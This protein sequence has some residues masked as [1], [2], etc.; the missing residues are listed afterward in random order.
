MCGFIGSVTEESLSDVLVKQSLDLIKHRGPDNIDYNQHQVSNLNILFGHTRLSIIDLTDQASQP[1]T[2]SCGKFSIIFNGEIYNY[3]EIREELLKL[4]Y[5]FRTESDTEV[6]LNSLICWG[7]TS[8]P[9]FI[10]MFSFVF[11]DKES[12]EL[13][14]A[15][16]AFGIKPFFY[17][18]ERN[19][20]FFSS[21]IPALLKLRNS[22]SKPNLQR[23]YDYL[24]H[25]EYDSNH[26]S[27]IEGVYHLLPAHYMKF[28]ISKGSLT[29]QIK[30]WNPSIKDHAISYDDAKQKLRDLFLD[31]VRLHLRSDVPIGIALSGGIDSSAVACA[32][33]HYDHEVEINTFS[34]IASNEL[35][36]EEL[37][38]DEI[39][40]KINAKPHKVFTDQ[41]D[42]V[43]QLDKMILRQGEPFGST[44]IFAHLKVFE[45][46]KSNGIKVT[47]DGQGAD[48]ILAGYE[49]Y[50]GF[51]MLSIIEN[52]GLLS[53]HN[54]ANNWSKFPRR[55]YFTAWK[56]LAKLVLPNF[57]FKFARLL[58]G[59]SFNPKWIK[60][61]YLKRH[62]VKLKESRFKLN[63]DNKG[64]RV[65]EALRDAISKRGLT[66][67]LRHGDRNSMA[68]SIESRV[69]FLT[70]PLVEFVLSLPEEYLISNFGE[71]KSIFRDAMYSIV[72]ESHLRRR[73]KIG[74]ETPEDKWLEEL[75]DDIFIWIEESGN[76]PFLDKEH[77]IHEI[78]LI[79]SGR[80]KYDRK[81]WRWVNYIRWHSL[82]KLNSE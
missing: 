6:L 34:Y 82:L 30:W 60:S 65:K 40:K 25:G 20:L 2:S 46:A 15:R 47:L 64:I 39:N 49:G 12:N 7:T 27:F 56:L 24:I 21:E 33:R 41:N 13:L 61:E 43:D 52:S 9:L 26:H 62:K 58:N 28:N 77:L 8:L 1:F 57:I 81:V 4:G 11:L 10:G 42:L 22:Q 76:I 31:S 50:P 35:I 63:K 54:Y 29:S 72:P 32:V 55:N 14:C 70:L 38:I 36:S 59:R 17:S 45:D 23:A 68:F 71:T 16:D 53:A 74:F 51:K 37:W 5:S 44:S 75:K 18:F 67:L 73:D 78:E 69:P 66:S 3:K 19:N 48:E 80:K 79:L